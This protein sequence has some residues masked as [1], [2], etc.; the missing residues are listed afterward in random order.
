MNSDLGKKAYQAFAASVGDEHRKWDDIEVELQQ[1]WIASAVEVQKQL[2]IYYDW[3]FPS[4]DRFYGSAI[5]RKM[6]GNAEAD[7]AKANEL[8]LEMLR[9]LG[10]YEVAKVL[11]SVTA[12]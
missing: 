8:L 2:I 9:S 10:M 4:K 6:T 3:M 5:R 11:E 1:A 7:R 12:T